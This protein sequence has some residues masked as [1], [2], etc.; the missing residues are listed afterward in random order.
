MKTETN[1]RLQY[2]D[3]AKG[4]GILM[5]II[6]HCP[7]I[8]VM[9]NQ[10]I[11]SVHMPLFFILSGYTFKLKYS[12][13]PWK[14]IAKTAK[15]LLIPY[16][17]SCLIII[18]VQVFKSII[19]EGDTAYELLKWINA[20]WYGS[21]GK[22]PEFF[23]NHGIPMTYIGALWFLLAMFFAKSFLVLIM[24]SRTPFLWVMICLF[25]GYVSSQ[26]LFWFPFSIQAGLCSVL[27]VYIGYLIREKDLFSWKAVHWTLKILMLGAWIYCIVFCGRFWLVGNTFSDGFLDIIGSV[28]GTFVIVYISQGLEKVRPL[29]FLLSGTGRLSL[30][31]MCAHLIVLDCLKIGRRAGV[32]VDTFHVSYRT[33]EIIVVTVASLGLAVILYFVPFINKK[34]YPVKFMGAKR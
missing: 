28:C 15:A 31:I 33:A 21:G 30:G 19:Y 32:L 4:I 24:R 11:F 1:A 25:I 17:I 3:I 14:Y 27:F 5:V 23:V 18:A 6:G 29:R 12:E 8:P 10:L 34:L 9:L 16:G 7:S 13:Q 20:S 22:Y 2:L 26:K